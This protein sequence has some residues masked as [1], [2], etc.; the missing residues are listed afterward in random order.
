MDSAS[1]PAETAAVLADDGANGIPVWQSYCLG[2]EPS[3][4]QSVIL[5]E[6]AS[7]QPAGGK[8][9]IAAK[10][11]NVPEGLSGAGVTASLDRKSSGDWVEQDRQM[12]LSGSTIAFTVDADPATDLSFFV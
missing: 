8:I 4:P 9:C 10:N 2:L 1:S 7:A 5:C 6:A 11:L 12:V 3:N